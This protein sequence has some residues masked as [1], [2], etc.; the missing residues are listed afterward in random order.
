[1]RKLFIIAMP[2]FLLAALATTLGCL[3]VGATLGLF[4]AGV[5]IAAIVIPPLA[6]WRQD[7]P[8]SIF[9]AG[10]VIDGIGVVWL[11]AALLSSDITFVRWF[12]A[13]IVLLA[14]GSA[15]WA[16]T[17]TLR[18]ATGPTAAAAIV[19]MIESLWLT[20]PIYASPWISRGP[21]ALLAPVH[22][23]FALNRVFIDLGV[24][25]QQRL[26]YRLTSLGQDVPLSLPATILPCVMFHLVIA[27]VLALPLWWSRA[28]RAASKAHQTEASPA[29]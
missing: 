10:G 19:V 3:A 9:A 26:M 28:R 4:F 23:L 24:W 5:M 2:P 12:Q 20:W 17:L 8:E 21:V 13:Y 29:S 27:S 7:L 15:S 25:T 11:V 16:T 18:R 14:C 6:S 22:P 1:M